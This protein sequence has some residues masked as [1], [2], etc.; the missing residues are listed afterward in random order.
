MLVL[1]RKSGE[2]VVVSLPSGPVVRVVVC[3]VVDGKVRLG[4]QAPP[5]VEIVRENA[6]KRQK[7]V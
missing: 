6:I 7:D 1:T 3:S 2:A 5:E 4:F